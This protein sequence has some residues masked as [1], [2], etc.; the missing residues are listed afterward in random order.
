MG[1]RARRRPPPAEEFTTE[2]T[3]LAHD[4]RGIARVAQPGGEGRG[5]VTF[6]IGRAHV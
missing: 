4:G 3:D 2:V 5:K 1:G 6:K